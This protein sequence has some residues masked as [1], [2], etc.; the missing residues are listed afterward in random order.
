MSF[1]ILRTMILM[2]ALPAG[3]LLVTLIF[4]PNQDEALGLIPVLLVAVLGF[5]LLGAA[6]NYRWFQ[7]KQAEPHWLRPWY[8]HLSVRLAVVAALVAVLL[9]TNPSF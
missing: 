2:A 1:L 4:H 7:T 8:V 3:V 5:G 9:I 6:M